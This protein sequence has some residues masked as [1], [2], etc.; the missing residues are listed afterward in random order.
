MYNMERGRTCQQSFMY[1]TL[2]AFTHYM[3]IY[4]Y[5]KYVYLYTCIYTAMGIT[6]K[7]YNQIFQV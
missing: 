2:S 3:Y 6:I 5:S 4:V 7:K 1:T